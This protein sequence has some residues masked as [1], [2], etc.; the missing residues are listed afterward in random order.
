[1]FLT[2]FKICSNFSEN[3]FFRIAKKIRL[4]GNFVF[5]SVFSLVDHIILTCIE[6]WLK[7]RLSNIFFLK[8][9]IS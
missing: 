8:I 1:M 3:A 4:S 2:I 9:C 7:M 5:F 6:T